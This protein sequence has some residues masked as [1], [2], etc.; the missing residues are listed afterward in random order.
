MFGC[1]SWDY[2]ESWALKNWCFWTVALEKT[3]ESPLDWK[4]IKPVHPKSDQSW[5]FIW[6]THAEAEAPILWPLDVKKLTHWKRPWCWERLKA[7]GEGDDRGWNGW[8]V[9]PTQW[10]WL[11]ASSRSWWWTEKPGVLQSMGLQRVRH[12]WATE[13]NCNQP[14][15]IRRWA[16]NSAWWCYWWP[17]W[18]CWVSEFEIT[19]FFPPS[20]HI[21]SSQRLSDHLKIR[22]IHLSAPPHCFIFCSSYHH[23]KYYW[24]AHWLTAWAPGGQELCFVN[25]HI[26]SG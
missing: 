7:G 12:D 26:L 25:W 9:S 3:L 6:R 11:W 5:I 20:S 23:L 15:Q 1:E 13:L 8:M 17:Q 22:P 18:R 24:S 4:E 19:C 2:K 21:T 10:T 14:R 16:G